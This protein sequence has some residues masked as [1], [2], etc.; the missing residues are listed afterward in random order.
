MADLTQ[1]IPNKEKA[2]FL[3]KRQV[4]E[5]VC[6]AVNLEG[7]HYTL[8][9]VQ[10]L[11]DGVTVGGHTMNDQLITL[12][13]AAAWK[14]L[15]GMI[16]SNTFA[17]NKTTACELHQIAAQK[18]A[19]KWGCFRTGNVTIAG[20]K[21]YLPPDAKAL[22]E[23]WHSM[24][25]QAEAIGDMFDRA[26]FVFLQMARTQFFYDVNKRMGRFMMNG[27]LLSQGYPAINLPAKRQLTFNQLMLAF[28]ES[29]DVRP[30]TDFMKSCLDDAVIT[31]MSEVN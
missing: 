2:L 31:I 14:A 19:L 8:P 6:D 24:V 5:L 22:D 16:E 9:E 23:L 4:S 26:I 10:T 17:L 12:N 18:E 27:L 20:V 21:D 1:I 13:Q 29:N 30:M 25:E 28:Y 7:I 11:L 3:A 15:F